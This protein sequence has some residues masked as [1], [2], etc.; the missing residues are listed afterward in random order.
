ML[1][2]SYRYWRSRFGGD[3]AVIGRIVKLDDVPHEIVAVMP[4]AF[5][6]VTTRTDAWAPLPA[7]RAAFYDRLNFSLLVGRLA[8]GRADRSGR[9]RFSRA[10][11]GDAC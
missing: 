10:D 7:D 1:A 5:E 6:A 11:A 3:T 2:L 4:A 9:S 8:D